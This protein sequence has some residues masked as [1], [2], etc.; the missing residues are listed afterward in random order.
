MDKNPFFSLLLSLYITQHY[1]VCVKL[2]YSVSDEDDDD[3][4]DIY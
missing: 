3:G 1:R 2:R 4:D